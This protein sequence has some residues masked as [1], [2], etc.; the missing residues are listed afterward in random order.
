[1]MMNHHKL[2]LKRTEQSEWFQCRWL[3]NHTD[4]TALLGLTNYLKNLTTESYQLF[5]VVM[6]SEIIC[7]GSSWSFDR[8]KLLLK[9]SSC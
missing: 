7:V 9:L 1:M 2:L 6:T 5:R 3:S 4:G 8:T